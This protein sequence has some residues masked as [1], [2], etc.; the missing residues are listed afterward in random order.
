MNTDMKS[1]PFCEDMSNVSAP[2]LAFYGEVDQK[3]SY[4]DASMFDMVER[5]ANLYPDYTAVTFMGKATKFR[6][7]VREIREAARAF[8][9]LGI[10]RGDKVTLCMPNCPQIVV[11]FYRAVALND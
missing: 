9:A 3:L 8:A 7:L 6:D 1:F 10:R 2:W 5:A 4:P 11:C